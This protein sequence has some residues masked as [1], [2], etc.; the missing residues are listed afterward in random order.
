MILT[1]KLRL[2]GNMAAKSP[3]SMKITAAL[4][5]MFALNKNRQV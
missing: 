2:Y 3:E 1:G 5:Y 4:Q